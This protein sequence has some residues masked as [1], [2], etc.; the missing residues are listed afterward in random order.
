MSEYQ[1]S[2]Q[3]KEAFLL[4]AADSIEAGMIEALLNVNDI[5]VLKKYNGSGDY[6]KIL[7]GNSIYG[8]DLFVPAGLLDKAAEIIENSR[9]ASR[10]DAFPYNVIPEESIESDQVKNDPANNDELKIN[11][12][13]RFVSHYFN[14]LKNKLKAG[15]NKKNGEV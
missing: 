4:S 5:P 6:L 13:K 11:R 15:L 9:E 1:E 2:P 12:K 14:W 8:V 7:M 3:N 10:D